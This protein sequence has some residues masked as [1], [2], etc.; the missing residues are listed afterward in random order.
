[1]SHLNSFSANQDLPLARLRQWFKTPQARIMLLTVLAGLSLPCRFGKLATMGL[2]PSWQLSLQLEAI[3]NSVFGREVMF[4]YGPLGYLLIHAPVSK[5]GLLFF[6]FFILVSLLLI[7]RALLP[8]RPTLIDVFMAVGVAAVTQKCLCASPATALFT[9]LCYWL[10]RIH[11]QGEWLAVASVFVA[12]MVL[13]FGKVNY[14]LVMILLIPAYGF[15]L[16]IFHRQRRKMGLVLLLG[17]PILLWLGTVV[18]HVDLPKYLRSGIEFIGGYNEAMFE[19]PLKP[20]K[21]FLLLLIAGLVLIAMGVIALFG[22]RRISWREEVMFLPLMALASCLLFKNAFVRADEMHYLSFF[23]ALPLLL[24]IWHLTR[25]DARAIKILMVISI[26]YPVLLMLR[27]RTEFFGRFEAAEMFPINYCRQ[28]IVAPWRETSANLE[29]NYPEAAIPNNIRSTIGRSSVDVMPWESSIAILNG[30]NY[31]P[32]PIFQSYTAY[33]PALDDLNARFLVSAQAPAYMLYACTWLVAI[34]DRPAVWDESNAKRVLLENYTYET[35]FKLPLK[36]NPKLNGVFFNSVFLLRHTPC[37]RQLIPV[38]T[39]EVSLLLD[40][41][42]PIP[43]TTNLIFLTL[44][45]DR[46]F[47]GK[48]TAAALS[49]NAFTVAFNYQDGTSKNFRAVLP[50]LKTG[51]LVN[52]RV[53][54]SEEIRNWLEAASYRNLGVAS[55]SFTS[56]SP[57]AFQVPFKGYL[58]E[59][60]LT[61]TKNPASIP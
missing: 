7:Y 31:Q 46:T 59:Y 37:V 44:Q 38:A 27:G 18:W 4:T 14:G 57:W 3:K 32:R 52:Q 6:D 24:A 35:E 49:P 40:Q 43:A 12:A 22:I 11:D 17:F 55:I 28:I 16:F 50:I 10:W 51:V 41:A 34:D 33:T 30:L 61:E 45:A 60:R 54:S 23:A 48:L 15:G 9:I 19:S 36:H 26:I 25:R 1:M 56:S 42:L 5:V 58:V 20:L 39:N 13:F 47:F 53:E 21:T 8:Q 2:D 29:T